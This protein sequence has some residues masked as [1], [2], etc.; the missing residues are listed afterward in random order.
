MTGPLFHLNNKEVATC[1]EADMENIL[2]WF[3]SNRMVANPDKFQVMFLGLPKNSNICI[4]IDDLVLV[5]KDYVKLLGII[6]IDSELKVTDHVKSL[7]TKMSRKVT[8]FSRVA[9]LLEYNK[10]KLQ[11]NAFILSS[12]NN[13]PLIWMFC[14]KTANRVINKIHK[15]A[16]RILFNDYEALF[17]EL[18]QRNN[19]QTTHLK[20]LHKLM[21]KIYKSLNCQNPK[22]KW[23]L[24][25]RKEHVTS[26]HK[27]C[28]N[29]PKL[30]LF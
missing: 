27:I 22:F 3:D 24:F 16:L 11:Y 28:Y 18:L 19:E 15:R 14:G 2:I 17:E 8:E 1:M 29:Y 10:A 13:C 7:C 4:E 21:T 9:R 23:D 5:P 30:I 25:I 12:L 26:E 20:N 6:N